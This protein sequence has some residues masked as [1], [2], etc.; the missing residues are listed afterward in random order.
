MATHL[1]GLTKALDQPGNIGGFNWSSSS[2]DP[3][4]HLAT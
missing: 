1:I 3:V 4:N 2:Y